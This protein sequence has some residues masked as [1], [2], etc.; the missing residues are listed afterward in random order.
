VHCSEYGERDTFDFQSNL[1]KILL[2]NGLC[3]LTISSSLTRLLMRMPAMLFGS[4]VSAGASM[5][6]SLNS[7][8]MLVAY[9][10]MVANLRKS[11]FLKLTPDMRYLMYM[12]TMRWYPF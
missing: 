9:P 12:A 3:C 5:L 1:A 6:R 11:L 7:E 2:S 4:D 10:Q 8:L